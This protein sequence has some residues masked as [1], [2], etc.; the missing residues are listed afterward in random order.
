MSYSKIPAGKDLPNDIYVAIEIPANHAPIKYEIDK[1]SDCLFV[2]RFM[3]TPMFYPAN[4][5]FI[6]RTYGD[7]LD[8]LD[9]LVLCTE[10]I[11]PMTLVRCYPIGVIRMLDSGRNDDKVIGIPFSDPTYNS[12]HSIKE[13]PPHVFDEMIHFFQVYK[14]L[15]GKQ[16]APG[17]VQDREVALEVIRKARNDYRALFG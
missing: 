13:L 14:S 2:D 12:Y 15:E 6:P 9:V 7:D 17:E 1:D 16:T 11:D 5:G 3:A 10:P 8:P 4:Y